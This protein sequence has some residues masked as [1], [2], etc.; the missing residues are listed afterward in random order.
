MDA[1]GPI[2]FEGV[3]RDITLRR[4]LEQ[5]L[6]GSRDELLEK[7]KIIDD[8]YAHI[9][10]LGK[11]RAIADHTAEVAHELR[12]PLTIIGG[13]ARRMIKEQESG[14]LQCQDRGYPAKMISSEIQRLEKILAGLIAYNRPENIEVE[15]T[16]PNA[17]VRQVLDV[18][19]L[20]IRQKNL[21]LVQE[22]GE[23]VGYALL[24][25]QRFEQLVRNLVS[26]AIDASPAGGAIHVET[27]VSTPSGKAHEIGNLESESYF[28][29]KVRNDGPEIKKKDLQKIF[30]PFFTTKN[31]GTGIGLTVAKKIVQA[32]K[33]S[34]SV[35]S[36]ESGTL[37]TVWL[38][39]AGDNAGA[40]KVRESY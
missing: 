32:H 26:N 3:I 21:K 18:Y 33:G 15:K 31:Y 14:N 19:D 38:P 6:K 4:T 1:R 17:I 36:G 11:A 29:M 35:Q 16:D 25:P 10:E 30:S 28:Q 7:I 40:R 24:D 9:V 5:E 2:E 20:M 39:L 22:L 27:S 12:Q 13:F 37:F 8:L 34:I 23:E